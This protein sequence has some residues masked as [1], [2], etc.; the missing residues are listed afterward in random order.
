[1]STISQR[2][3]NIDE[4]SEKI[5]YLLLINYLLY[6]ADNALVL[7]HRNSEWCGHAPILELDIAMS[8]IALD[9]IG[10]ARSFYQYA[11]EVINGQGKA[12]RQV[13]PTGGD[14]EG[15]GGGWASSEDT[16]AYHRTASE[17]NNCLLVEQPK[18]DWGLT[19]TRQFIFS[20]YQYYLYNALQH[21]TD[22]RI[23]AI[24]AKALKEVTYHV[25]WSSEWLIRLGAGT[26]ESHARMLAAIT[27]LKPFI[28]ELFTP[29]DYE[30]AAAHA[31]IGV[32]VA[33]LQPLWQQKIQ[34]VFT[35]ATLDKTLPLTETAT[36][37]PGKNG[38]H[39]EHLEL[40]LAEMQ[41]L[42]RTHPGA[43]W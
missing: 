12:H 29:A 30:I 2:T 38:Q 16:L 26:A 31:G 17:F 35:E 11:A 3:Y 42:Q 21:S 24:A 37:V 25:R 9:L 36:T 34:E 14:L 4:A 7:G 22:E 32:D 40:L 33:A 20:V 8:N 5:E 15:A 43:E 1:M 39:T 10:Q 28:A 27:A 41:H 19:V 6:L 13:S 23:A 18:G